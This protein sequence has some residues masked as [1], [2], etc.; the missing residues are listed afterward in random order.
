MIIGLCGY[1]RVGKDTAAQ[2]MPD[3]T[4]FAFADPLKHD[5][6]EMIVC[7][8]L[9]KTDGTDIDMENDKEQLRGLL[10]EWG[11]TARKFNL[12]FWIDRTMKQ[13]RA[14]LSAYPNSNVVITDVRYINEIH[15]IQCLGGYVIGIK[16]E[17][18][19][20]A[21]EEEQL[22][23]Q[24]IEKLYPEIPFINNSGTKEE[25]ARAVLNFGRP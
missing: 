21:N 10:V 12:N 8:G 15:A 17:G 7:S 4:R 25:L 16:R 23:F 20:P 3:F 13:V 2:H 6:Y 9:V 5:V 11:R 14:H 18:Y 19:G 22:S 1:A 24:M